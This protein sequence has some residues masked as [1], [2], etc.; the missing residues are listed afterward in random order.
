MNKFSDLLDS[1][2]RTL[3]RI[4]VYAAVIM[5]GFSMTMWVS[6]CVTEPHMADDPTVVEAGFQ[7]ADT[8]ITNA[9]IE[10]ARLEARDATGIPLTPDE[11]A[12]LA[13]TKAW[14]NK[15]AVLLQDAQARAAAAGRAPDTGDL[16]TGAF[17]A[18][19]G[20][21]GIFGGLISGAVA[22]SVRTR[23]K[24]KSF[25]ALVGALDAVKKKNPLFA[26]QLNNVGPE[27]RN[28][29]GTTAKGVIDKMRSSAA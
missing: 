26:E 4:A 13:R 19:G 8:L 9:Q 28:E 14:V 21:I 6:S 27:L 20:P 11:A 1:Q 15:T 22:E 25:E 2:M 3:R 7:E 17:N 10:I 18:I 29:M 12:T 24:R 16:V 23:K 5:I